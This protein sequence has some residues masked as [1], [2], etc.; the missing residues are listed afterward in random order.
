[1]S[2]RRPSRS[3]GTTPGIG[4]AR[5]VGQPRRQ[6]VAGV[7][8]QRGERGERMAG[9]RD[10][11]VDRFDLLARLGQRAFALAQ[12]DG[13]VEAGREA[14]ADQREDLV[15]LR[16]RALQH[17]ALLDQA[18]QL[19]VVARDVDGEQHARGGGIGLGRALG[20]DRRHRARRGC[21]RRSRAPTSRSAAAVPRL[22]VEPASGG[23]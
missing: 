9:Q 8:R 23:G 19:H 10:L 7:G 12:L 20:A 16:Q 22:R 4:T 17:V 1:M 3:A 6:R 5:T 18:G 14:L 13:G 2:A 15:A 11:L 21:G